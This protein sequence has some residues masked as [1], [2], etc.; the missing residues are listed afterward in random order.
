MPATANH[1]RCVLYQLLTEVCGYHSRAYIGG[2]ST[3]RPKY[4]AVCAASSANRYDRRSTCAVWWRQ[5]QL[6]APVLFVAASRLHLQNCETDHS[7]RFRTAV[8]T[9][10]ACSWLAWVPKA[11][12]SFTIFL[13]ETET[14]NHLL[15]SVEY[16]LRKLD[17]CSRWVS[18]SSGIPSHHNHNFYTA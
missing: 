9:S 8:L 4:S 18:A 16:Y 7:T 14:S 2:R 15:T 1:Q 3:S 5:Q 13:W 11:Q 6:P 17:L 10:A 12:L